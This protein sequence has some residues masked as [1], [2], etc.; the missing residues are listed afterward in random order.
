M[1]QQREYIYIPPDSALRQASRQDT[2]CRAC[3]FICNDCSQAAY[4][5][6]MR[7]SYWVVLSCDEY[8]EQ[9]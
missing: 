2:K 5:R 4:L 8:E 1:N 3:K 7:D 6:E 9:K